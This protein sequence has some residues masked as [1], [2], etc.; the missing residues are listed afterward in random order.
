[1][2]KAKQLVADAAVA[3]DRAAAAI[4]S[5]LGLDFTD[6]DT[7]RELEEALRQPVAA[8]NGGPVA[9]D[10]IAVNERY[11][12][13]AVRLEEEEDTARTQKREVRRLLL[14]EERALVERH[15]RGL[16]AAAAVS[17]WHHARLR[18]Q[19]TRSPGLQASASLLA[20][21][22]WPQRLSHALPTA[23]PAPHDGCRGS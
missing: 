6:E 11:Q 15:V 8:P 3:V 13:L 21:L 1:M 16:R 22:W 18:T 19:V 7:K 12:Q 2:E 14:E 23:P 17:R 9:G 10:Q 20:C 5:T 4:V